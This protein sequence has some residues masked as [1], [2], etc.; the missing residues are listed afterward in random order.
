MIDRARPEDFALFG[1]PPLFEAVRSTSNLVRPDFAQFLAHSQPLFE[2]DRHSGGGPAERMLE[3]RLAEFHDTEYC[4][5]FCSGFWALVLSVKSLAL[6]GQCEVIMP[7][8]TYRRLAD[9]VSW[10]GLIPHFCEVDPVGLCITAETAEPCLNERTALIL[11]VHP[12][13]NCCDAVGLEA[14]SARSGIPLLFDSVESVFETVNDRKVGSFGRAECFSFHASKLVNGF[15]G[16]YVT[17]NDGELAQ[18]LRALRGDTDVSEEV[19]PPIVGANAR[20][21]EIHAA[22]AL[23]SLDELD[24]QIAR[25]RRK[26]YCYR[27]GLAG[28]PGIR[29]LEFDESERC[30]YKNIVVELLDAWPI[31]RD[32]TLDLLHED[33]LLCR[34]YYYPALHRKSTSYPVVYGDLRATERLAERFMTLPCGH[35]VSEDDIGQICGYLRALGQCGPALVTRALEAAK[36][37]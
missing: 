30:A 10:A 23:A 13:V 26:Y 3:Q 37:S 2:S 9:L 24:A 19:D 21:N 17:T 18:R 28:I 8:L 7:S 33:N 12:I 4:V 16:G 25:N 29:L 34:P 20:Q 32:M 11:G 14:L 31:P 5:S 1:A 22:M 6:P 15:E 35:F 27:S 36:T